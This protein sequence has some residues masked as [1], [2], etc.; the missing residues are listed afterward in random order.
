MGFIRDFLG[1]DKWIGIGL[2][3]LGLSKPHLGGMQT[4]KECRLMLVGR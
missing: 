2:I 4:K 3:G 1:L